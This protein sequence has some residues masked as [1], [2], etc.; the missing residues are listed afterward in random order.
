MCEK[1]DVF[2]RTRPRT[3]PMG[4]LEIP[5][6]GTIRTVHRK[7]VEITKRVP[8]SPLLP[9]HLPPPGFHF[10]RSIRTGSILAQNHGLRSC[11]S[12]P[13]KAKG[14]DVIEASR[15]LSPLSMQRTGIV[16]CYFQDLPDDGLHAVRVSTIG[17]GGLHPIPVFVF[18]VVHCTLLPPVGCCLA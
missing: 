1:R 6:H 8:P 2:L 5:S 3:S 4:R 17:G 18:N 7:T 9:P 10:V 12:L 14:S 16:S 11:S 15:L 13:L